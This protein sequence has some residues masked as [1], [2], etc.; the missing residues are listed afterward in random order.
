M[1]HRT[2]FPSAYMNDE[3][4]FDKPSAVKAR[5]RAL[6]SP[7][8]IVRPVSEDSALLAKKVAALYKIPAPPIAH[9]S[10]VRSLL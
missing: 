8:E 10:T 5:A 2:A 1:T 4:E 6:A 3:I 7:A 9:A